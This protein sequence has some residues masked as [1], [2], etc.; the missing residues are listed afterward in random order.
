MAE[1]AELLIDCRNSLGEGP[2]W[3]PDRGELFWFDINANTLFRAGPDGKIDATFDFG[4][5]VAAAA[6]VDDKRLLV[7]SATAILDFDIETGRFSPRLALEADNPATRSNDSRVSPQGA[8]WIGTMSR[9]ESGTAGSLYHYFGGKLTTLR[10][11]VG[12][13]NS[14]CFSPDGRIAY[15]ADSPTRRIEKIAID[16]GTG[17]PIGDWEVFVDL[18][19]QSAVPDGAVVDAEGCLWSAEYGSGLVVRYTPDGRRDRAVELPCPN[20]TCPCFG[21]AD[22]KTLYLTTASQHM[23]AEELARHPHAGSVFAYPLDVP[24]QA[25]TPVR[26]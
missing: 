1:R 25:E 26:L 16:P 3:H 24:G 17:V 4:E 22:L 13:P 7:A 2:L 15:F 20:V 12:I 5:P 9:D 11:G 8:W 21:G 23:S 14:T 18:T 10:K 19:G 6:V